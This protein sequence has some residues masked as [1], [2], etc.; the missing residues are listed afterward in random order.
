MK[1][2]P[3]LAKPD[4]ELSKSVQTLLEQEPVFSHIP[5]G[6][7]KAAQVAK[8]KI[9]AEKSAGLI[10]GLEDENKKLK[11]ENAR[12]NGNLSLN[13]SGPSGGPTPP[14]RPEDMSMDELRQTLRREAEHAGS[15]ATA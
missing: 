12:L 15:L 8:W 7:A 9:A 6:F 1:A 14:K 13:G 4:S 11:A 2:E 10:S 5:D 3:E